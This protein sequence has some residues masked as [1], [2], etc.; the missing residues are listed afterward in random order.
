[1]ST[2]LFLFIQ[3]LS[4]ESGAIAYNFSSIELCESARI[5]FVQQLAKDKS[6]EYVAAVC[7]APIKVIDL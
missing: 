2:V 5:K 7:V 3:M 6:V 4:G 1:M